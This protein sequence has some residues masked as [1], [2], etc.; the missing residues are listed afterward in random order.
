MAKR[1]EI[2]ITEL[3][4]ETVRDVASSPEKWRSFLKS[5]SRNYR[6]PFDEQLLV[7]VQRPNA[8]AVLELEKWNRLFGRWVRKGST[9][10]AVLDKRP[11]TLKLKYYYDISDTQESY[12]KSLVRPVPLW[13]LK[14]KYREAVRESL[15]NAFGAEEDTF[16]LEETIL[17]V[18][19]QIARDHVRDYL[20]DILAYREDS[21]LEEV[22]DF[23][24]EVELRQLLAESIAY[25][26]LNRCGRNADT[27]CPRESFR[28]IRYFNTADT[29]NLLGAAV[30]D[31]AE[32]AL[33]EI[34]DTILSLEREEQSQRTFAGQ[35]AARYNKGRIE[36]RT[37]NRTERGVENE[38]DPIQRTKRLSHTRS[39]R[40]GRGGTTRW[41]I[42][43]PPS[44]VSDG[45][46]VRGISEF[47]DAG[48]TGVLSVRDPE[49][50]RRETGSAH[51]RDEQGGRSYRKTQSREP[52]GMARQDERDPAERGRNRDERADL[53]LEKDDPLGSTDI[54]FSGERIEE[55]AEEESPAVSFGRENPALPAEKEKPSPV[56]E[57]IST[58]LQESRADQYREGMLVFI[59]TEEYEILF[60]ADEKVVLHD[61]TYPLFTKEMSF[62]EF[63]RKIRENPV[64]DHLFEE[65]Q[66]T[67]EQMATEQGAPVADYKPKAQADQITNEQPGEELSLTPAWKT[68][69]HVKKLHQLHSEI[70]YEQRSQYRITSDELGYGT[71]REKF[72]A[73]IAAI[74][75][76]KLCE[77]ENRLA[78]QEEQEILAGYVGWGSLSDAF[79]EEKSS[80]SEEYHQLRTLLTEAE[81]V[82]ARES[83]LTA[84][85]TP[86]IVIRAMYQVLEN[87]GLKSGNILEPSCGIGN[88]IGMKPESLS[89]CKVYGVELDSITGRIAQQLYQRS[90]I[91]VQGYEETDLPD[92]FF[93][94]V[95]GNVPFGNYKVTDSKYDKYNFLI[96]DYFIAKAIDQTRPHGVLAI[97]T[98]SGVGGGTM[99]KK[100]DYARRYFAQ[101]CDLLGAVR[102]PNTT[103]A[104]NAGTSAMTDILFLQKREIPRDLETDLPEWVEVETIHENDFVNEQ[105]ESRH[106]VVNLNSYFKN[107]PEMVLGSLEIVSGPYGPML[108]CKPY[109]DH[110]LGDLLS[111]AVSRIEGKITEHEATGFVEMV[112]METIPADPSVQNFSYTDVNGKI[113]YRENSRMRPVELSVTAEHRVRGMI[114][115]RD[116]ARKLIES[117]A[118]AYSDEVI[119]VQQRKLNYLYDHFQ[120]KYGLLNDRGNRLAFSEDSSYPLLCSL[121]VLAE[122]GTLERK[123]DMFTKRTIKPHET[124][125]RVDTASEA[126]SLS[127]A[128]KACVDMDYMCS[129]TGKSAEE[130]EQELKG[131]IFRLP[132]LTGEGKPQFVSEDEYLSGNVRKKLRAAEQAAKESEIYQSNVEALKKVQ[133]K[134]LSASE[135]S[136]R[137]GTTWI[138][139]EDIQEFVYFLL[140]TPFY[141]KHKIK[142]HYSK[143]TG[144][145]S[146]EGK[147]VDR[148]NPKA[149]S[150]YG[151]HRI[152]AYRIVEDTLNLREVKIF[153]YVEDAEGKR[154]AILNQKETALAQGKQDMIKQVFRDWICSDPV[155]R[156]RLT[157][158]YNENFNA[159]RPREY[160]GSHLH[161]YGMNP[162][163][164]L[165]QHQKNGVAR[166]IY[167][168][169][170]LLAYVVG[171]GKTFTMVAA[172]MEMKRLGLC[173]KSMIVVPNHIIDQFASEWL[174]LYPASNLLVATK[175]DFETKNRKKFCAR[176][177]TSEIDAVIIGHSQ[178]EKIPV[179]RERQIHMIE[180]QIQELTDS[181]REV[182]ERRGGRFS[183]RR[184]E[185]MKKNL[186]RK[187]EN[188]HDQS[189]KDNVV[190][191]EELGVDRLFVDEADSYK[192]LY[193]QTKMN[194]V[195][196]I[197]QTEAQKSADMFMKCQYMDELTGGKGIIF[198]TGTPVSNSMTELYTMQRYLQ[199][200]ELV[201]RN[202]HLFDLW[203]SMFG[204]TVTAIE[205]AP[206][207]TG[208]R[209]KTRFAKF[210]NLPELMTMFR[211]VADIQTADML[212]LPVPEASYEVVHVKPSEIQ[213]KL[214]QGLAERAEKVRNG[215]VNPR[216]DNMLLI[217]NDGRKLALDQRLTNELL[218][219]EPESK[220]NACVDQVYRAWYDGKEERLTQLVFCDLST[221]KTDG[222]FS[223]YNDMRDKLTGRGIPPEEVAFI[224]DANTEVKKKELFSKVRRGAVRVLMGSTFKMGAGTNVQDRIIASHDLDCPWRPRDLEQ[225]AG[226]T[227]RQGNRNKKVRIV[228]Y[229]T[230]GTFDAY[231][232]QVLENKQKFISQIMTSK[233]PMRTAD[234]IDEVALSYAEI[235]ALAAENPYI[236][237]KMDLDVQVSKL[238]L[239]KQ[240]FLN[241]K[242]ELEDKVTSYYPKKIREE[243]GF[244]KGYEK[245]IALTKKYT[246]VNREEFPPMEINGV[247]Y[248]E[249]QEA[250]NAILAAC[251]SMKSPDDIKVGVYRGM[252]LYLRYNTIAQGFEMVMQ[253]ALR[254]CVS[255]GSDVYGN[256]TRLDNKIDSF[257]DHMQNCKNR[258]S[259]LKIQMENAQK[260]TEKEFSQEQEL[261]EKSARLAELNALLDVGGKIDPVFMD[262]EPEEEMETRRESFAMVR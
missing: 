6:L 14:Q 110:E 90:S 35:N 257:T 219:D 83:T 227:V 13:R 132:D 19:K 216:Q 77:T 27:Y 94:V 215:N 137:L 204:E 248:T 72:R 199:Y 210:Y 122:D 250:G 62:E 148:G 109:P 186:K 261:T 23:N 196:G 169:N 184:M 12:Q 166:I 91:T 142:V 135:I 246:P 17:E 190:C 258:L 15:V 177:A 87:L 37:E 225:R 240:S 34:G 188:L 11:G 208:Y 168:G 52:D 10:I 218:P 164:Q 202:L 212:K 68:A 30:S 244:F 55:T 133:P 163:I 181:I 85:Y 120:K 234:D 200:P 111:E 108:E 103:F 209:M 174:Q 205:L 183:L 126:L 28:G 180:R 102:L 45:T 155:R 149:N 93:D 157:K 170:T 63:D 217:T 118:E 260:E 173:S 9:G 237:E 179:S 57:E 59:G 16:D 78:T 129:V 24:V 198:A 158:F 124:V 81:Y 151:T 82:S 114:A 117:Q 238:Q 147:S 47:A 123:A 112:D 223:V 39:D 116:C 197:A 175:R 74:Q 236:K 65:E 144:T 115:I 191:F 189:K 76:L 8:T 53:Q 3:Y 21:N 66:T 192:N 92:N 194:N 101:R 254:H 138:P 243:E 235:K 125:E 252:E 58:S 69:V 42:R 249:K 146:V 64:N 150:T 2:L 18:A 86:P 29:I 213:K 88:F 145:W 203:A 97:V 242:Y 84:F 33:A 201:R 253:G 159:I 233:S 50:R 25:M 141:M 20:A 104:K 100:D 51:R 22:D 241:Q 139:A 96:H 54:S 5:A 224:H 61:L 136:V 161:F 105:G 4:A 131:V 156:Q 165:R 232:Y 106:Q 193:L 121:E 107:R 44:D 75:V 230:E 60:V 7:H 176:I 70:P 255:L 80:W 222:S 167:G 98:F 206:E 162:E 1:K 140:D 228:R 40:A 187:L 48:K 143:I 154:K 220:V 247:T 38:D 152:N 262:E 221:P 251:K 256:I 171:A 207:G 130:I 89:E 229:V 160:D 36:D 49:E 73:N 128:E 259:N 127:L 231:L 67:E 71:P 195:A 113:Y 182:K 41:E 185:T 172:A 32:M 153:D 79:D 211:E 56:G 239:L 31:T 245:D 214:V 95:I 119:E 226:R 178:F 43:I 99:D 134:D 46:S 26:V